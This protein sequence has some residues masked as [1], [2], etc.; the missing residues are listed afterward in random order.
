VSDWSGAAP[1]AALNDRTA[2]FD[3]NIEYIGDVDVFRFT[4][5]ATANVSLR[6]AGLMD[7]VGTLMDANGKMLA[8]NDDGTATNTNFGITKQLDPGTYYVMVAPWDPG[9]TGP[10]TLI[11]S[12]T[13]IASTPSSASTN[14]TDLW[15]S[16][17]NGWGINLA[18]QGDIIFGVL[19]TYDS[20]GSPM[21]LYMSNGNKQA[22]G[23]YSGTLY[24]ANGPFFA[25]QNWTPIFTSSVGTMTINFTSST[26]ATLT[27]SA[28]GNTVTK[29]IRRFAF[30]NPPTVCTTTS[31]DRS[32]STN[33]QDL[34]W[35]P[36]ESGWGVTVAHEGDTLFA[37]LYVYDGNTTPRWFSMSNGGLVGT[38][39]YSGALYTASGPPFYTT[40]W[41]TA[42]LTQVGNMTFTF[43][44]GN[45][46]TL[47][48][49][50]NGI[51]VVKQITR[52]VFANPQ[53]LCSSS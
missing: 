26:T 42:T 43:T 49:T 33:Y 48:Y 44:D 23:S 27:Y 11:M 9:I 4:L 29:A 46:G 13:T 24:H 6:S 39:T 14:Y 21:W 51:Q 28:Y 36:N 17:E 41:T 20:D 50:V 1:D 25:I 7:T 16:G 35:N 12:A 15:W 32:S 22:D 53:P 19:Y 37:L 5:T 45:H 47:S 2:S 8:A 18:H 52:T 38:R 30:A 34:W 40:P 10:Y 3:R 31:A